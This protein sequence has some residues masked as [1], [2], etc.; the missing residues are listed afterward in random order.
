MFTP[1]SSPALLTPALPR[2]RDPPGT[3]VPPPSL[4]V[5][6][7]VLP[8]AVC[9]RCWPLR[10]APGES[11]SSNLPASRGAHSRCT[12]GRTTPTTSSSLST[13]SLRRRPSA[14]RWT[15]CSESRSSTAPCCPG[16]TY[17]SGIGRASWPHSA[18]R[19]LGYGTG[20][21]EGGG[22][23]GAERTERGGCG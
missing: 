17:T 8:P 21:G 1:F 16:M 4:C 5:S 12:V 20:R 15:C 18:P 10:W 9:T 11:T 3:P 2:P 13:R 19:T 7:P 23:A 14:G 6:P 22:G